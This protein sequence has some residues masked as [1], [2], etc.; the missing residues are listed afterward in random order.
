MP[1][2]ANGF[3]KD[4]P[5]TLL[6]ESIWI[7]CHWHR[8]TRF[9]LLH[10]QKQ[11]TPAESEEFNRQRHRRGRGC[12]RGRG[13]ETEHESFHLFLKRGTGRRRSTWMGFKHFNEISVSYVA[14]PSSPPR[15]SSRSRRDGPGSFPNL[16][17][18]SSSEREIETRTKKVRRPNWYFQLN[19]PWLELSRLH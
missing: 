9:V 17:R 2:S 7:N 6:P 15:Q 13:R 11:D 16:A 19:V 18:N 14:S 1:Y 5:R 10:C 8:E 3:P 12:G 4:R